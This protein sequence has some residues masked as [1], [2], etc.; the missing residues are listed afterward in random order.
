MGRELRVSCVEEDDG[1][2][3]ILPAI[4]FFVDS[5]AKIRLPNDKLATNK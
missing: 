5:E 4:E 2:I 1:S 3:R